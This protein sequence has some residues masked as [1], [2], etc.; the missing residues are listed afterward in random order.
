MT[1]EIRHDGSG[2]FTFPKEGG[3]E[4][5]AVVGSL[6][7]LMSWLNINSLRSPVDLF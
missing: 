7:A 1:V 6:I 4:R 2:N 3:I 5:A